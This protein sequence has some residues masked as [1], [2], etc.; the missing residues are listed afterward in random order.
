VGEDKNKN[1]RAE[2]EGGT[3]EPCATGVKMDEHS[4]RS[5]LPVPC[6]ND[7]WDGAGHALARVAGFSDL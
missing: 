6:L 7:R 2:L 4:D 1:L 3:A 5:A